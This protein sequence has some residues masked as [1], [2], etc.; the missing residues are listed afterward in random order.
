MKYSVK[1]L[2]A[3]ILTLMMLLSSM[4]VDALASIGTIRQENEIIDI[5]DAVQVY[6]DLVTNKVTS[7]DG[8]SV[9]VQSQEKNMPVNGEV[10]FR[11]LR[12]AKAVTPVAPGGR[13]EL[14]SYDIKIWNDDLN[15]EWQP[16][17]GETV[18]V[19]VSLPAPL[20]QNLIGS[21]I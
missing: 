3:W 5:S 13:R 14:G 2:T 21:K 12:T 11:T 18:D 15:E 6:G 1:K 7:R 8:F 16:E 19:T 9:I 4:P 20:L 17:T 10:K